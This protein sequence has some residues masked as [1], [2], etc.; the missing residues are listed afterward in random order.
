LTHI[1]P[2]EK[3][4]NENKKTLRCLGRNP[5]HKNFD[6]MQNVCVQI[7]N[8]HNRTK[9]KKSLFGDSI[10]LA[11]KCNRSDDLNVLICM[12]PE[13]MKYFLCIV[14]EQA[15]LALM[16]TS[17]VTVLPV[18]VFSKNETSAVGEG[19]VCPAGAPTSIIKTTRWTC[20]ISKSLSVGAE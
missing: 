15:V 16:I 1:T 10:N 11:G 8:R 5:V 17:I 9:F 7:L 2:I 13:R 19:I 3:Y 6:V 4:R 20:R 18:S 14:K 12:L